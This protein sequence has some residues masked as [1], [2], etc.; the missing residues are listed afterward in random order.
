LAQSGHSHHSALSPASI[1]AS[2]WADILAMTALG[3]FLLNIGQVSAGSAVL[4]RCLSLQFN[5]AAAKLG[6]QPEVPGSLRS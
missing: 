5:G 6:A 4:Q 1:A 3:D 2:G